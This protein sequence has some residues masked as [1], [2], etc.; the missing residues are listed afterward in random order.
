M[1]IKKLKTSILLII[2][3]VSF[4]QY[5]FGQI[6]NSLR[7][8][9]LIAQNN[10]AVEEDQ[11]T[12]IINWDEVPINLEGVARFKETHFMTHIDSSVVMDTIIMIDTIAEPA[13]KL[14]STIY[15]FEPNGDTTNIYQ[16]SVGLIK[17]VGNKLISHEEYGS[18]MRY[19]Y[20]PSGQLKELILNDR[21]FVQSIEGENKLMYTVHMRDPLSGKAFS[22]DFMPSINISCTW[23]D[24]TD[25]YHYQNQFFLKKMSPDTIINREFIICQDGKMSMEK[26][27]DRFSNYKKIETVFSFEYDGDTLVQKDCLPEAKYHEYR[28]LTF[29]YDEKGNLTK[30]INPTITKEYKY[31]HRNNVISQINY[32]TWSNRLQKFWIREIEY[33]D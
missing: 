31:D 5:A 28:D 27:L 16:D 32:F 25:C 24:S 7:Y 15:V 22:S 33:L 10:T 26:T 23:D 21:K 17:Y 4:I 13:L 1:N 14:A 3:S 29:E 12:Y 30:I 8:I 20:L 9:N 18:I 6:D 19:N 11:N 2:L